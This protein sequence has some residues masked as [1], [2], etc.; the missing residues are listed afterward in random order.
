MVNCFVC[1]TSK[2]NGLPVLK[3]VVLINEYYYRRV[4]VC[5]DFVPEN[6]HVQ[7]IEYLKKDNFVTFNNKGCILNEHD[8]DI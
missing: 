1:F 3:Y 5:G 2:S 4:D 6:C 8:F 7:K